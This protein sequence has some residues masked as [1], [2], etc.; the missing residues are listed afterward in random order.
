MKKL[1]LNSH[2]TVF[3]FTRELINFSLI[4]FILYFSIESI[5]FSDNLWIEAENPDSKMDGIYV[6][7]DKEASNGKAIVSNIPSHNVISNYK[8]TI[9][10]P[11]EADYNL[12]ARCFWPGACSG[13]YIVQVNHSSQTAIGDDGDLFF[14][15]WV[16]GPLFHLNQGENELYIWNEEYD[17]RIDKLLITSNLS[18][19]PKGLGT[20]SMAYIDFSSDIST[21]LKI[22]NKVN[23]KIINELENMNHAFYCKHSDNKS[24]KIAFLKEVVTTKEYM[25]RVRIKI[26]EK[27]IK[28]GDVQLI[29][30]YVDDANFL[31]FNVKDKK[32]LLNLFTQGRIVNL[33]SVNL[34]KDSDEFNKVLTIVRKESKIICKINGA[35]VF[36]YTDTSNGT[37]EKLAFGSNS[38]DV[39][40]DDIYYSSLLETEKFD[41]FFEVNAV[42][43]WN[44]I[45]GNWT[46]DGWKGS[47][48]LEGSCSQE[49]KSAL[50]ITGEE[51]WHDY[52]VQVAN[53]SNEDFSGI[54]FNYQDE[55]NYYLFKY[56]LVKN[57]A[58]ILKIKNNK[59]E[60]IK[61]K[62]ICLETLKGQWQKLG[63]QVS[64]S[65]IIAYI[66]DKNI[67]SII[68]TTIT[69]GKVGLWT[70]SRNTSYF[71]DFSI[72]PASLNNFKQPAVRYNFRVRERGTLDLSDWN[73]YPSNM[74]KFFE[75]YDQNFLYK[76]IFE[77]VFMINKK[78]FFGKFT[79]QIGYSEPI[80]EWF[81][82][83]YYF[84]VY[85]K[86][87]VYRYRLVV[88]NSVVKFMRD[89]V[90][91]IERKHNL[92]R[93][94]ISINL[95]EG[96][97]NV[98]IGNQTIIT[99]KSEMTKIDSSRIGFGFDGLGFGKITS[100]NSINI[101]A[102]K[103]K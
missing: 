7:E 63:I 25:F 91:L 1:S 70:S 102:D 72:I 74:C 36:T 9:N 88:E 47:T 71:D 56:S 99:Y 37:N 76:N 22:K 11:R 61:Q 68:D 103:I 6:Y 18:F 4:C 10:I 32:A 101:I 21:Y 62:N 46:S 26:P 44:N 84:T 79:F 5:G 19:T 94:E 77:E 20:E 75:R 48:C 52:Q 45:T 49:D 16:K 85:S 3:R 27:N 38:G 64:E 33:R 97:W 43:N 65:N 78:M 96:E 23:W 57:D 41:N 93:S 54:C 31:S 73:L 24:L 28:G 67:L 98:L 80:D 13:K 66:D 8:Y 100:I 17:S 30:N 53:K 15:H 42:D 95:H 87:N 51:F 40:F 90:V 34:S 29:I 92:Q 86:G 14:W 83:I 59:V 50:I 39:Y 89:N 2:S 81:N 58:Q 35:D 69:C 82:N 55:S 60:I 12:W